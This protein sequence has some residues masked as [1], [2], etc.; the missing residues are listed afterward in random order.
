MVTLILMPARGQDAYDTVKTAGMF[1][2]GGVGYA[3]TRTPSELA[4]R[5]LLKQPEPLVHC[6]KLLEEGTPAGQM[7]GLLGLHLLDQ[8]AF[9]AVLPRYKD[10][11]A[12]FSCS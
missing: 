2:V 3:G 4:F 1:T 9:Q 10:T 7:Y 12:F 11:K 8:D 6:K 5:E